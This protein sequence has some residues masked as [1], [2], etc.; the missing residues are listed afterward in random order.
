MP[1]WHPISISGYHIRESGANAVQELGFCFANAVEYVRAALDRGL[2]I[3][4]FAP[5]LSF[6]FACRNDFLEEI[7]KFRAARRIWARI[8]KDR[9]KARD[10]ESCKLRFHTQTSG[11]TLTAQQPDNNIVRVSIQ[12][13]AGVLGGTQSLHTNSRDEALSLPTEES[14]QIALR[15]QQIIAYESGVT[16]T[17]DPLAGS[18]YL[19]S[20]TRTLEAN[21]TNLLEK[22]EDMGG[23][24]KAI[25][26]GFVHREI[27]ESAY[28]FQKSVDEG[29]TIIVGINKFTE[30]GSGPKVQRIDPELERVQ[31]RQVKKMKQARNNSSVR[32]ALGQLTRSTRRQQNL[33]A[34]ILRAVRADCTVGEISDALRDLFG[35]YRV[36]LDV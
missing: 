33:V 4:Q 29:R 15:T 19:E 18:Y 35:E 36:R 26:S 7:A 20:L 22:V 6:F 13:L 32:N 23:A 11:E 25:E 1:H 2:K 9:F 27:Q 8:M 3:D 21:A 34:D 12:A 24:R 16:K 30:V 14:V 17:A 10:P 31:I 28:R 5:Q